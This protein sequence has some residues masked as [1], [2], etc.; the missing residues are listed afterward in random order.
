MSIDHLCI[1]SDPQSPLPQRFRSLFALKSL[2]GS[3]ASW[4]IGQ[5]LLKSLD[6]VLLCHEMAYVLGQIGNPNVIPILSDVLRNE[7]VDSMIR[8]EAAEALGAIGSTDSIPVLKEFS[9]H[10]CLEISQ[11]CQLALDLIQH[12][13]SNPELPC[14]KYA[15]V[16]PAPPLESDDIQR[17]G[18]ELMDSS[19][20]LFRRYRCMFSLRDIGTD[21]AVNVRFVSKKLG[22]RYGISR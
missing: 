21:E 1:L 4:G 20:S 7:N 14:K 22:P 11:T 13:S 10:S 16:D 8:H 12:M 17:L 9:T 18:E 6:N 2:L 5:A 15:S 3:D 19:K